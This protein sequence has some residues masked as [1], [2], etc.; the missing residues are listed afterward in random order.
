MKFVL[1]IIG[2]T[3]NFLCLGRQELSNYGSEYTYRTYPWPP[4]GSIRSIEA[5]D[6]LNVESLPIHHSLY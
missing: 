1:I 3:R 6:G 2:E 5:A 4:N